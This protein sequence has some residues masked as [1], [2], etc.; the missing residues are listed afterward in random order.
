L[1]LLSSFD[2]PIQIADVAKAECVRDLT[3]VCA[4]TLSKWFASLDGSFYKLTGT[5]FMQNWL[6]AVAQEEAGDRTL[7]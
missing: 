7:P 5:P 3:K 4:E 2:R 6:D 1:E